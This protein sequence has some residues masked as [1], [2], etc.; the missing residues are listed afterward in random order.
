VPLDAFA[1]GAAAADPDYVA[2]GLDPPGTG[3][4]ED[5]TFDLHLQ[6]PTR[7]T[8]RAA[9]RG[10]WL[11]SAFVGNVNV[12]EEPYTFAPRGESTAGMRVVFSN[13]AAQVAGQAIDVRGRPVRNARILAFPVDEARW[14]V[15]T[16]YV[17]VAISGADGRFAALA[18]PPGDYWIVA[19]DG[20]ET[21]SHLQDPGVLRSLIPGARRLTLTERQTVE[22]DAQVVAPAGDPEP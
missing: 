5:G 13:A 18:L 16:E 20:N 3:I 4:N 15:G 19:I 6:G 17:Q 22:R 21:A 9:P 1:V 2:R 12:A 7:I 10:W 11:K 14:F 8:A